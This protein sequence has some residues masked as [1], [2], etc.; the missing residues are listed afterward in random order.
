MK[1]RLLEILG[2]PLCGSLL[3][4]EGSYAEGRLQDGLLT[5]S[6]CEE[7]Y[8]VLM[9]FSGRS[10]YRNCG[11]SMPCARLT[12]Q[13]LSRKCVLRDRNSCNISLTR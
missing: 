7:Q 4:Y 12:M 2:C 11:T 5:C 6:G 10:M 9:S 8:Q 13:R 1:Q 3:T